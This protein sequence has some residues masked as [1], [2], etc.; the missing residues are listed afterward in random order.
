MYIVQWQ[1]SN[2]NTKRGCEQFVCLEEKLPKKE[3]QLEN[4]AAGNVRLLIFVAVSH[5]F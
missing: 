2:L 1:S 3:A 4:F 5:G